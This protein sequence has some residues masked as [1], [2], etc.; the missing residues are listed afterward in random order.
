[1]GS[2]LDDYIHLIV[3]SAL[4]VVFV[5]PRQIPGLGV[6][7]DRFPILSLVE[8]ERGQPLVLRVNPEIGA[9]LLK[10]FY[11]D[12]IQSSS[13]FSRLLISILQVTSRCLSC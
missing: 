2:W 9:K 1:M 10:S 4:P 13:D 8:M 7:R 3:A 5:R 6:R 11:V 12:E